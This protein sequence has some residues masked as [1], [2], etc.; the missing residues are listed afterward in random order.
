[1]PGKGDLT[2]VS[3]G[4]KGVLRTVSLLALSLRRRPFFGKKWKNSAVEAVPTPGKIPLENRCFP[5]IVVLTRN[6]PATIEALGKSAKK[7]PVW[8]LPERKK[9]SR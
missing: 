2:T 1:M 3:D 7:G 5:E 6:R 8:S 4:K 9:G